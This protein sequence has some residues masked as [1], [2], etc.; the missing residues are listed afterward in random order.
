MF[1]HVPSTRAAANE[2]GETAATDRQRAMT[3][4]QRLKRVFNWKIEARSKYVLKGE[5]GRDYS[6]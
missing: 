3:L 4:A 1:A 2:R 6:T 5:M